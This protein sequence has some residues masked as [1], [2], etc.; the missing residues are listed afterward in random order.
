MVGGAGTTILDW[1]SLQGRL[2]FTADK[3]LFYGTGLL[4]FADI[5]HTYT[6][7]VTGIAETTSGLHAGWTAGRWN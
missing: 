5:S 4:A 2:G 1:R 6:N 7:L 3:V